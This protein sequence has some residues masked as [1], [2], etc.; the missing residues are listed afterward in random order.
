MSTQRA[1]IGFALIGLLLMTP[2]SMAAEMVGQK[3]IHGSPA[4]K[5]S[6]RIP[7]R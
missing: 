1:I 4:P 2:V 6:G 5:N 3:A 7:A